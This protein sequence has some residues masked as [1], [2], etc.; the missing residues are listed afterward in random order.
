ME[1]S[2]REKAVRK[3]AALQDLRLARVTNPRLLAHLAATF[4]AAETTARAEF[5]DWLRRNGFLK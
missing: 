3:W 1:D 2:I 5:L 4:L